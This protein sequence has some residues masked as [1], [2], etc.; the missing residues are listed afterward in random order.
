MKFACTA[1]VRVVTAIVVGILIIFIVIFKKIF[2]FIIPVIFIVTVCNILYVE[3]EL[4]IFKNSL[5][6]PPLRS[7]SS[8]HTPRTSCISSKNIGTLAL[9][10]L[11]PTAN[12]ETKRS[13]QIQ[14][15][16]WSI[17]CGPRT[18]RRFR[19]FPFLSLREKLTGRFIKA[20]LQLWAVNQ[21]FHGCQLN[22]ERTLRESTALR[23]EPMLLPRIKGNDALSQTGH[24]VR[25]QRSR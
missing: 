12:N 18:E 24:Y 22:W 19:T 16:I 7:L 11:E 15:R 17:F 1:T 23:V 10:R 5:G 20:H 2:V 4:T 21:C 13:R 14:R 3:P 6:R 25:R 8:A 9:S